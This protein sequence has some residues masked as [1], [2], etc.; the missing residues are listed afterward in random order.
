MRILVVCQYYYPEPFRLPDICEALVKLGHEVFAVVGVPNYPMGEVYK[1]Y[2]YGQK[3]DET[4][5][6]VKVHRCYTIPRRTGVIYRLLNYYSYAFSSTRYLKRLKDD[7]D[8]VFVNQQSPVMMANGAIAYK[9]KHNKKLVLYCMDL[10]PDS[11]TTGG[12]KKNTV[13][14]KWFYWESKRVYDNSDRIVGTSKSFYSYFESQFGIKNIDYLPQYAE[15]LFTPEDCLKKPDGYFDLMFAGNVGTAQSVNTIIEAAKLTA[16]EER[17]RWHI[18]GDGVEIENIKS[19]A[20]GLSNVF[21]YGRKSL[22]E[23]PK[24]YSTADAMLVTMKKDP[25]ISLTLP[26]KVQTYMAA[27]KAII[28]A[29]DGETKQIINESK[30]GIC[31][32]AENPQMLAEN[33]LRMMNEKAEKYSKNSRAYYE[34]CFSKEGFLNRLINILSEESGL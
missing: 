15:T 29:I 19:M 33:A 4:I 26:G 3:R 24:L 9:K 22:E 2:E 12:I 7:Y 18:V 30:S 14:Y 20:E 32:D 28:G 13:I 1:G 11:L 8:V 17:I 25:V 27:G 34:K 6:G 5:N 31:G 10:W 21:I 23:M 16:W